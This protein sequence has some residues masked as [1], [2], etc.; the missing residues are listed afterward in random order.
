MTFDAQVQTI[1]QDEIVPK[2]TDQVLN[3]NVQALLIMSSGRPWVGETLKFPVKLAKSTNGGAFN[4]LTEFKIGVE[5]VRQHAYFDPRAYYQSVTIG[6]I[7]KSINNVSKS[8]VL[9]LVKVEMESVLM[10]MTDDIG[11][12]SYG[13]GSDG[14]QFLGSNAAIDDGTTTATYGGL[15]SATYSAWKATIQTSV[16]AF[17]FSKARTLMNSASVGNQ[18]PDILSCDETTFGY[19]ESDYAATVEG[20]YSV[21]EANRAVLTRNGIL[22]SR[23]TGLKGMAGFDVLYYGGSPIVK[24]DKE[25]TQTLRATNTDFYRWYGV[26][27]ADATPVDLKAMYHDGDDQDSVN[28]PSSVGFNWTGFVRPHK[29]YV[30]VGQFLVIGNFCSPTRRLHSRS[31][32]ISS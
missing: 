17:D 30:F 18:K 26:K 4:D 5:N 15:S 6:G 20:N 8:Q 24:D 32:G 23:I 31:T 13:T 11:T 2:V 9:G 19:I 22:K 25:N 27:A 21:A 29:Q 28:V 1:T 7:A 14:V 12:L 3:S 16:G 10:D